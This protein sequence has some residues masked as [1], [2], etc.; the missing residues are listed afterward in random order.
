MG[1]WVIKGGD[2]T[3]S[4]KFWVAS[5]PELLLARKIIVNVPTVPPVA[6]PLRIPDAG[7]K[8][9]P[10]G[11]APVSLNVGVGDPVAVI[12]K[13]LAVPATNVALAGLLIAGA[14]GPCAMLRVKF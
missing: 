10:P 3:L 13:E 7:S 5:G 12:L 9:I 2:V 4:V 11:S 14:T 1:C 6:D 8:V